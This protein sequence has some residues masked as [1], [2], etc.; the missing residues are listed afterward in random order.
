MDNKLVKISIKGAILIML[1]IGF[2]NLLLVNFIARLGFNEDILMIIFNT[3]LS[4]GIVAYVLTFV[5]GN[6]KDKNLF[7]TRYIKFAILF[8]VTAYL[9][10]RGI[11]I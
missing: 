10:T 1:G 11:F 3:F 2:I 5:D 7:R 4:S 6:S 9:W 8:G